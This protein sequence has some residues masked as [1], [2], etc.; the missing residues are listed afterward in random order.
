MYGRKIEA[1][2]QLGAAMAAE[3]LDALQKLS[4]QLGTIQKTIWEVETVALRLS[5]DKGSKN[6]SAELAV[7]PREGT[8]LAGLLAT[9]DRIRARR[10]R[11]SG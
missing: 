4:D 11:F 7:I 8:K 9:P 6:L 5:F 10:W 3:N 1:S 2:L